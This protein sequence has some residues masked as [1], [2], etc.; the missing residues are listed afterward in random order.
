MT[1]FDQYI[2][3]HK[4]AIDFLHN[5]ELFCKKGC[6]RIETF[7]LVSEENSAFG[8][9]I[10]GS[11][12]IITNQK[13]GIDD[14]QFVE[15]IQIMPWLSGPMYFTCLEHHIYNNNEWDNLEEC[16]QWW[17]DLSLLEQDITYNYMTGGYC[18]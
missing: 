2:G 6:F 17:V 1:R 15:K 13:T 12:W 18:I 16:F 10:F 5:K 3:L 14:E 11:K 8:N 7:E 4:H 9:V